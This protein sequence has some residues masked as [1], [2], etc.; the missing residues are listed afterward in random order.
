MSPRARLRRV[1]PPPPPPSGVERSFSR[2]MLRV[3]AL[4]RGL[5][6][7]LIDA[8]TYARSAADVRAVGANTRRD[9]RALLEATDLEAIAVRAARSA[10]LYSRRTL[11]RQIERATGVRPTLEPHRRRL[12]QLDA[13]AVP[14]IE[15]A[16]TGVTETILGAWVA[17]TVKRVRSIALAQHQRLEDV[18]A[19][20]VREG[21]ASKTLQSLIGRTFAV[22]RSKARLLARDQ[23]GTI[24]AQVTRRRQQSAGVSA[25]IW[26]TVRDERVRESHQVLDGRRFLWAAPPAVGHPGEDIQCRCYSDPDMSDILGGR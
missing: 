16:R 15:L 5:H 8:G 13:A 6:Q 21:T 18:V 26:R 14:A 25:Y 10:D 17:E 22:G 11:A 12:L 19:S 23:V 24:L 4:A 9:I 3:L 2:E 1:A 7:P 20:A